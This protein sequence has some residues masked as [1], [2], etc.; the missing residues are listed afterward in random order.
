M[1]YY[2]KKFIALM[3][4]SCVLAGGCGEKAQEK[5]TDS[6]KEEPEPEMIDGFEKAE[7]E[8]FNSYAEENGLDGTN[9]Y[10]DGVVK[11]RSSENTYIFF[12][13]YICQQH[14]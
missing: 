3:L 7:Y 11:E 8:K 12:T 4:A 10:I 6:E 14:Q 9:I 1:K 2:E 5:E 13:T